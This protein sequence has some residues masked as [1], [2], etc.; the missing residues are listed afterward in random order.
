VK[1][2]KKDMMSIKDMKDIITLQIRKMLIL[3]I[4]I[5]KKRKMIMLDTNINI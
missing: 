1:T 2:V 5:L 3:D 4:I